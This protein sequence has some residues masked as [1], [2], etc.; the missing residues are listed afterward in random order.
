MGGGG[1]LPSLITCPI[2]SLTSRAPAA[3]C[4]PVYGAASCYVWTDDAGADQ[5]A[6][7]ADVATALV[8]GEA[9]LAFLDDTY[10]VCSPERV[11]PFHGALSDALWARAQV[12]LNQGKTRVWNAAERSPNRVAMSG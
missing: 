2:K 4:P 11:A 1:A 7:L 10:I 6:A 8:L 9:V 5:H 3:F 12:Q